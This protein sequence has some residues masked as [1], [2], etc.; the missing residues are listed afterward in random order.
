MR[1]LSTRAFPGR[2]GRVKD[3]VDVHGETW[4]LGLD[5]L[6][7]VDDDSAKRIGGIGAVAGMKELAGH[8]LAFERSLFGGQPAFVIKGDHAVRLIP[9]AG[10]TQA[11]VAEDAVYLTTAI[12][13]DLSM[14]PGPLY[15]L[16][17][18]EAIRVTPS[19]S[20]VAQ[21]Y[22]NVT[23]GSVRLEIE[24]PG[25]LFATARLDGD[26]VVELGPDEDNYFERT[27]QAEGTEWLLGNGRACLV[28]GDQRHCF[29]V[30][31]FR[32]VGVRRIDK[33][34]WLLTQR[35]TIGPGPAYRI[36]GDRARAIPDESMQVLDVY[37]F[38]GATW[39][40]TRRGGKAG[41]LVH[42]D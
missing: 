20:R 8:V 4:L 1:D 33:R 31:G 12:P 41:P 32:V 29:N 16:K 34:W 3:V 23:D 36:E 9:D 26:R 39:L 30:P 7:R 35:K 27:K 11:V 15:R 28:A 14:R 21:V 40:V 38:A 6:Y 13:E 24:K 22:I 17:G 42:V 37:P 5:G 18:E 19:D 2:T 25:G 10:V